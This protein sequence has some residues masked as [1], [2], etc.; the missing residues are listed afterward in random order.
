MSE[1]DDCAQ[2]LG[3][4][5]PFAQLPGFAPRAAQQQMAAAIMQA[6]AQSRALVVEAGTG[7]GKTY[8][9]L[10][11]A[12]L[13]GQRTLISTGTRTLQDQLF[14][15]DLP[16]V[17]EVL[18]T[19]GRIALL[20]GRANYLCLY[21][22]KRAR[23]QAQL[24]WAEDRLRAVEDWARRTQSGEL[25]ELGALLGDDREDEALARQIS[26]TADNCLGSRCP[27]FEKC[28]VVAA[29]RAAQA[30]DVVVIN[31]HLLLADFMLKDKGFGQILS[32]VDAVIIDEAH[33]LPDLAADFFG[34]RV[35]T[36]QL[37]ELARDVLLE[38]NNCGDL[39]QLAETA[40][41]LSADVTQLEQL[42]IAVLGGGAA[43]LPLP[44]F[45]QGP[46]QHRVLDLVGE[47]LSALRQQLAP[48]EER[49]AE[50]AAVLERAANLLESWNHVLDEAPEEEGKEVRW[51]EGL[52][53]G[54]SLNATPIEVAED[55]RRMR[56][57]Y[58]GTWVFTSATLALGEDFTHYQRALGL[59]EADA[60]KLDSPFDYAQ[61]ARLYLPRGLPEPNDP[62]YS[63][64]VCN[65]ITPLIQ[66]GGGGAFVLCTSHR[67]LRQI[68][69]RLGT[70]LRQRVLVQGQDSRSA[71]L[72]AFAEDGNAVLVGTASF[73]EG[74]DVKGRALRLVIIDR[75]PFAA[76]G[77]PVYEARIEA[78]RRRGGT[79]FF[80]LQLPEA[81]V[82]LRQ[83]AGRLIRDPSDRGLLM[84]CDPRIT[85]KSYGRRVLASLPPMPQLRE[86]EAACAFLKEIS[87]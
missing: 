55:F 10:V 82:M 76:P 64:A 59:E 47:S 1:P 66:A 5:G 65:A 2:L 32:G 53:R 35:S 40:Q 71:L 84:L 87:A 15:R 38:T 58:P 26:S 7:T 39:P 49:N 52:L 17:R 30:A 62:G 33:Q 70:T 63:L 20:K 57:R 41:R 11:P 3:P 29:R 27:D 16:R 72:D 73:W 24:R 43:R 60:L 78:I 6:Y 14:H 28:H 23:G 69:E 19:G 18:R 46:A 75:L 67:A 44:R 79:P 81:I 54:G 77:D 80:E 42:F 74:V 37:Q 48:L 34:R 12:L 8:A 83:G 22:M 21:R 51:V 45:A 50:L 13:S 86:A 31:H 61:Q 9:Y 85:Q 25:S 56:E 36:R 68:G 4:A